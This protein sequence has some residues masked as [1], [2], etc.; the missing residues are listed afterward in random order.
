MSESPAEARR[1]GCRAVGPCL[2]LAFAV[3]LTMATLGLAEGNDRSL[4][5][6]TRLLESGQETVRIVCFG[7]SI[8]AVHYHT[9]GRRSWCDM[10]GIGLKKA[11]PNAKTEMINAGV[12]G[13]TSGA[14]LARLERDVLSRRPH[15]VIVMFGMNDS[16]GGKTD[17]FAG[18]LERIVRRCRDADSEVVLCTPNPIYPEDL[19]RGPHLATFA[20]TVRNVAKICSVPIADCYKA[21]EAI[22]AADRLRWMLTM[23]ETIHPGM[24]GHKLFAEVI[25]GTIASKEISLREVLPSSPPIMFAIDRAMGGK[26]VH[27]VAMPPY[28]RWATEAIR[29]ICPGAKIDMTIWPVDE[30]ALEPMEKWAAGIRLKKPDLV[31][32]AVPGG[33]DA[34]TDER[35]IRSYN[36]LLNYALPFGARAWDVIGIL[37]SVTDP[38]TRSPREDLARRIIFSKDI[39]P[40][41]RSKGDTQS[42]SAL[43]EKWIRRGCRTIDRDP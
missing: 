36:W 26:P 5:H 27:V 43:L 23:S 1:L 40:V 28:D 17:A 34:S 21:C 24:D 7:D 12:S 41:E 31:V 11:Y 37:P 8:T 32:V 25:V 39:S 15:L 42:P 9:G 38:V 29:S 14:G 30:T 13:N 10:V 6:V 22:Q 18:N 20:E 3:S 2:P 16:A 35:F 4:R 19:K 33:A